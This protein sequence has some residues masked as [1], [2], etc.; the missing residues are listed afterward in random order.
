MS[1]VAGILSAIEQGDLRA[2]NQQLPIVYEELCKLS[3]A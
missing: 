1:D 2:A 3:A